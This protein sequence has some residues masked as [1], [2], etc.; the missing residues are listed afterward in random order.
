MTLHGLIDKNED[1]DDDDV[2]IGSKMHHIVDA[3]VT[4]HRQHAFNEEES[5]FFIALLAFS[6][7]NINIADAAA[8]AKLHKSPILILSKEL[9]SYAIKYVPITAVNADNHVGSDIFLRNSKY[10]KNGTNLTF[11]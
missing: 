4:V 6:N 5:M 11:R 2:D 9:S 1:C 7:R 8:A 10:A 3:I